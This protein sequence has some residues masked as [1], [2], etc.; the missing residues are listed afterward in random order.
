MSSTGRTGRIARPHI[1]LLLPGTG[2]LLALLLIAML[3]GKDLL[4]ATAA[5]AAGTLIYF[6]MKSLYQK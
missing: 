4:L 3:P 6:S 5:P 1:G 2:A